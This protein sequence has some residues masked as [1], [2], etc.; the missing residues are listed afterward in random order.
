MSKIIYPVTGEIAD[1]KVI[2]TEDT[3]HSII[4][5]SNTNG[6]MRKRVEMIMLREN[7]N[8]QLEIFL[9]KKEMYGGALQCKF[10]GGF[11]DADETFKDAAI[12]KC[13]EESLCCVDK[14]TIIGRYRY[15]LRYIIECNDYHPWV[16]KNIP[17]EYRWKAD[18]TEVFAAYY[19]KEYRGVVA[20]VDRDDISTEGKW[21]LLTPEIERLLLCAHCK[22][23]YV[24]K[25]LPMLGTFQTI[26]EFK[27]MFSHYH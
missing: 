2:G 26:P 5:L 4:K 19:S 10:P 14:E 6:W 23:I 13:K 22:A 11:V 24:C 12:R 20:D 8:G 15:D 9:Q 3:R 27:D 16:V 17:E 25:Y 21:Y 7:N 18:Y 1:E